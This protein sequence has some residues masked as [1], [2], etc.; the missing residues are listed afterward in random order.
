MNYNY[1]LNNFKIL[2]FSFFN[3]Y[4]NYNKN[5]FKINKFLLRFNSKNI[6]IIQ[7]SFFNLNFK[8]GDCLIPQPML[9]EKKINFI[10]LLGLVKKSEEL[11]TSIVPK[12]HIL[13]IYQ[14]FFQKKKIKNIKITSYITFNITK[15][16]NF[17]IIKKNLVEF[18]YYIKFI[19]LN[20]ILKTGKSIKHNYIYND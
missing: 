9:F 13:K 11:L 15:I 12:N 17:F 4:L 10:N 6:N 2:K 8:M 16:N 7:N 3:L 20:K 14:I 19:E 18:I 5:I 1:N